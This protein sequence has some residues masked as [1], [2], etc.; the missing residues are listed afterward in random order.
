MEKMTFE[1]GDEKWK[2]FNDHTRK[3]RPLRWS[4][5]KEK[6]R[7]PLHK[8]DG[9]QLMKGPAR[10]RGLAPFLQAEGAM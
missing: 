5:G 7:E 6:G 1:L 9:G 2:D 4:I 10:L 3:K 8:W